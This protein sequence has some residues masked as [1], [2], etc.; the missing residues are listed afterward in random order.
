MPIIGDQ[1]WLQSS[2]GALKI[3]ITKK[4]SKKQSF[5]SCAGSCGAWTNPMHDALTALQVVD[6]V[7]FVQKEIQ[8]SGRGTSDE[9]PLIVPRQVG[10]QLIRGCL[11]SAGERIWFSKAYDNSLKTIIL[12][13]AGDPGH[14][15]ADLPVCGVPQRPRP[16]RQG[17]SKRG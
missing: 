15:E 10:R 1:V 2:D 16:L 12:L 17:R 5:A 13:L 3:A 7:P 9:Y 6:L 8:Q 4:V 11:D 14:P